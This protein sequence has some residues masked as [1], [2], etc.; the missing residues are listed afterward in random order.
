VKLFGSV[1]L[2]EDSNTIDASGGVGVSGTGDDGRLVYGAN[3]AGTYLGMLKSRYE[4][5]LGLDQTNLGATNPYIDGEKISDCVY[6]IYE[7]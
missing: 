4:E 5:Y 7:S 2:N 6:N 3:A 1:V